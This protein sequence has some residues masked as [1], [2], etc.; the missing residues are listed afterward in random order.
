VPISSNLHGL[1]VIGELKLSDCTKPRQVPISSNL[2]GLPVIGE[3]KTTSD[4][5]RLLSSPH[6]DAKTVQQR[7]RVY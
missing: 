7:A 6:A 2:H 4:N 3:L 5:N 1:P